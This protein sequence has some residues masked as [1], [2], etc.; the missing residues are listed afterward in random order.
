MIYHVV[1]MHEDGHITYT[2]QPKAPDYNQLSSLVGGMIETVPYFSKL[3]LLFV[4]DAPL[5]P[6]LKRGKCFANEEGKIKNMA[7][8]RVATQAWRDACPKGDP[9][10]MQLV[11]PI[12]FYAKGNL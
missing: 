3:D 1:F 6:P 11:G 5:I 10:R 12:V 8:N 2:T 9:V 4:Q 7:F